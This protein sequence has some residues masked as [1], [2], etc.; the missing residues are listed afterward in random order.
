M[1][2]LSGGR[3]YAPPKEFPEHGTTHPGGPGAGTSVCYAFNEHGTLLYT[4]PRTAVLC[5]PMARSK[6][7]LSSGP[8]RQCVRHG[9]GRPVALG[10][11]A[12]VRTFLRPRLHVRVAVS[13]CR[14]KALV[15]PWRPG[16][17]P[18]HPCPRAYGRGLSPGVCSSGPWHEFVAN[19]GLVTQCMFCR[20][21][22]ADRSRPGPSCRT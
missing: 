2:T 6:R 20:R 15:L 11:G 1:L 8:R 12:A 13:F 19:G 17:G 10:P 18:R 21:T 14:R 4:N 9:A 16:P 22:Q 3:R 7:S 5:W